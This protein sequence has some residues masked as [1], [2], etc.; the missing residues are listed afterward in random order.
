MIMKRIF[1]CFLLLATMVGAVACAD[2]SDYTDDLTPDALAQRIGEALEDG[3]D[4][5]KDD[6][7]FMKDYFPL[8]DGVDA[9]TVHYARDTNNINEFGIYHVTGEG[10]EELKAMLTESYL[11]ASYLANRDW[12]DSYIPQETAKLRDAEVRTYGNYIVY[13][14]LDRDERETL[15]ATVEDALRQ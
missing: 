4:Y 9:H 12:Y 6:S 15:F 11:K 7:D 8:P 2:T 14:I 3:V 5:V 10:M 1:V 13:A